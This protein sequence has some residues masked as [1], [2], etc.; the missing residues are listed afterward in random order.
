MVNLD[1][2][3]SRLKREDDSYATLSKRFQVIYWIMVGVFLILIVVH[4]FENSTTDLI[5][6]VCF[7]L[8]MLIFALYFRNFHKEY[9]TVDYSLPTLVMLEKAVHRYKPFRLNILWLLLAILLMDAGLTI[10]TFKDEPFLMVQ[11]VVCIVL[12]VAVLTGLLV[13]YIRY[14]PVR[15]AALNLIR[16][17]KEGG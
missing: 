13:W 6:A 17:I 11:L 4:I 10:G 14:K 12:V 9:G 16:E 8:A 2:L 3:I 1:A 7:F 5:S 15:D